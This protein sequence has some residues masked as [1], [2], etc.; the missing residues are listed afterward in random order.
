LGYDGKA[1][2][3]VWTLGDAALAKIRVDLEKYNATMQESA[4]V[5]NTFRAEEEEA[6]ANAQML[7]KINKARLDKQ[8]ADEKEYEAN[9]KSAMSDIVTNIGSFL[10]AISDMY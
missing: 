1:L 2:N 9:R 5:V 3:G 7:A 6:A 4:N 8:E 10:T